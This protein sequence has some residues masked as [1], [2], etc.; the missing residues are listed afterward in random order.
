[1]VPGGLIF[2]NPASCAPLPRAWRRECRNLLFMKMPTAVRLAVTR[3]RLRSRLDRLVPLSMNR[4]SWRRL[5]SS[6][7]TDT[8]SASCALNRDMRSAQLRIF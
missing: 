7:R 5:S 6:I 1:M 3:Y 4:L 2:T 8:G